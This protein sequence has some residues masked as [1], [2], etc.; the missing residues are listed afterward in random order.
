M[1]NRTSPSPSPLKKITL[2]PQATSFD[3]ALDDDPDEEDE[4]TLQL[5]LQEIQARLRLKKLQS[6]KTKKDAEEPAKPSRPPSAAAPPAQKR[7]PP[8]GPVVIPA[9]PVRR[10]RPEPPPQTS[11][12]RVLLGIDKGLS[13]KDVSLKRA[14]SLRKYPEPQGGTTQH[15]GYLQTSRTPNAQRTETASPA[16]PLT[17]NERLAA[18]RTEEKSLKEKHDRVQKARTQSFGISKTQ[19]E[20]FKSKAVTITEQPPEP[21]PEFTREEIVNAFSASEAPS[22]RKSRAKRAPEDV[23]E[24][25]ASAFEP[26]SS[27]H[28]KKRNVPHS[29][30][31]RNFTGKKILTMKDMLRDVK[32]PNFEL[33][34]YE[35]DIVFFAIVGRRSEPRAHK[36]APGDK[37]GRNSNRGKYMVLTLV[38]L[39][40]E[41]EMFLFDTGFERYWK[42]AEGTLLAILNPTIM[43]P[44]RGREDTGRFSIIINS[45]MDG[46]I[47]IGTARDLGFCISVKKDGNACGSWVNLKR[48]RYCEYHTNEAVDRTRKTRIEMNTFGSY[49]GRKANSHDILWGKDKEKA[50]ERANNRKNYDRET[51]SRWFASKS[52]SSAD[53][54]DGSS[55]LANKRE[56]EENLKRRLLAEERER[57]IMERLGRVGS[58]TGAEYMRQMHRNGRKNA[59]LAPDAVDARPAA[60]ELDAA[61]LSLLGPRSKDHKVQLGPAK[62]KRAESA[63][64]AT[65]STAAAKYSTAFGWGGTLKDKLSRMKDGEKFQADAP[66]S[67]AAAAA[68]TQPPTATSSAASSLS[69]DPRPVRKKTRFITEKGIRE[70]GR[71]SLGDALP[72]PPASVGRRRVVVLDDDDDDDL[73]IVR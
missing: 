40:F 28:L 11:P 29:V 58:G 47:E 27:F 59:P 33:P 67:A 55:A 45:D 69:A 37:N 70:A 51:Q 19:M 14:P 56:R 65:S 50:E 57:A 34:E 53:L 64:S 17:F 1:E 21:E 38:D 7:Q 44:P 49:G 52:L 3:D 12:K 25:E 36:A 46:V 35:Q 30:L 15:N 32:S 62:R 60:S 24:S 43:P 39:Q 8:S 23:P 54:I 22:Q 10:S 68:T 6:A 9:S 72:E 20:E 71:E 63:L 48:T 4:E 31:T 2:A 73:I 13:G 16:R 26:Y 5:K 61:A 18:A 42:I 41:L 66:S